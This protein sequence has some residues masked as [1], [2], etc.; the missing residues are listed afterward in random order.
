MMPETYKVLYTQ[1]DRRPELEA[2]TQKQIMASLNLKI[3][4]KFSLYVSTTI[5]VS[6]LTLVIVDYLIL[7]K[8]CLLLPPILASVK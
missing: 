3:Y 5:G 6:L 1:K 4:F 2:V 7:Q 8:L